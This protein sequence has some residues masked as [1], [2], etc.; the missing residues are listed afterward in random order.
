MALK[1]DYKDDVLDT[2]VNTNRK[3][4]ILQ[5][6]DGTVSLLDASVYTQNGDTFGAGDINATNA[7]VN[8]LEEKLGSQFQTSWNESTA[9]L[10]I[11]TK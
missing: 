7:K 3:Y 8:E 2:S 11:T 10:T 1:T 6:I 9:T 4:S 5:N